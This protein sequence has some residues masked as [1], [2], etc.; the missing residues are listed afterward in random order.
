LEK[1]QQSLVSAIGPEGEVLDGASSALRSIRSKKASQSKKIIDRL[2]SFI[3]SHRTYLQETLYTQ[4]EGRYVVPV[5]AQYKG[6]VP[7]LV[8]DASGSGQTVFIEPEIIVAEMNRL[9]ELEAA[10]REEVEKILSELS[11]AIGEKADEIE[12]G[13]EAIEQVDAIFAKADYALKANCGVPTISSGT[14]LSIRE[15]H[16]PLLNRETSVPLTVGVGR[17]HKCLMLTGANTGGK[18]VC[19]KTIGLYTFMLSCGIFPPAKGIEYGP[20]EGVWA[21]IGDEQSIQQSLS[22]FSGHLKNIARI[23]GSAREGSLI[24]FD[25]IGAGTDPLEGAALG[26][27]ILST[28]SEKGMVVAASTHYGE[29]KDFALENPNFQSAAMEFDLETLR[30]TFHLIAGA[31][32]SSHAFEISRRHG[33]PGDVISRAEAFLSADTRDAREKT[34]A[35]DG[36]LAKARAEMEAASEEREAAQSERIELES[37]RAALREKL[38]RIREQSTSELEAAIRE[39]RSSYRELLELAKTANLKGADKD[40]LLSEAREIESRLHQRAEPADSQEQAPLSEGQTVSVRGYPYE[41]KVVDFPREGEVVVLINSKRLTVPAADVTLVEA[42]RKQPAKQR[43]GTLGLQRAQTISGEL[44][45]RHLGAEEA[46]VSLERFF[47]DA[48]LAGLARA[49]IVH[50]KGEGV[51]RSIVRKFLSERSDV[52]KFYE[53][54]PEHGGCG[55]TFVDFK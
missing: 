40:A 52:A 24:L 6:K 43:R 44:S 14:F 2:Q 15:G 22:T 49:R 38:A 20:F 55:E 25:E 3:S 37:E 10:E 48:A 30:P 45:L 5:K 29:L 47:D 11:R 16:H 13:I 39:A 36:L 23:F 31:A 18:T 7:G 4:R 50:G 46:I 42:K 8:H 12:S 51:L 35:I 32:G 19:L 33:V 27:A 21:D 26:K 1:L 41:G 9:R 53:A 34:A 54:P 17:E 28:L